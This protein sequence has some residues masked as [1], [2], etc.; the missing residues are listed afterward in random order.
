[1]A[2]TKLK[3]CN[4]QGAM[5]H[6]TQDLFMKMRQEEETSLYTL[7]E[8]WTKR[9]KVGADRGLSWQAAGVPVV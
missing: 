1:M 5:K 9:T 8:N 4:K 2:T 6:Y 7:M 3:N